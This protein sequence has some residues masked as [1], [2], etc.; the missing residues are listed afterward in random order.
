[1]YYKLWNKFIK[2]IVYL[3][4]NIN[5]N[6]L[7][8]FLGNY[9]MFEQINDINEHVDLLIYFSNINN[10]GIIID[11]H[12]IKKDGNK[13]YITIDNNDP[14]EILFIKRILIDLKNK[15]FE[16]KGGI[17][18]HSSSIVC[19]DKSVLFIGNKGAGKTT[20]M[21]YTL[22][23]DDIKY[24]SNERTG[25]ILENN[26]LLTYGNPT[27]IN[28]R[29]DSLKQNHILKQRLWSC[30]DK[31]KYTLYNSMNLSKDCSERIVVSFN[32]LAKCLD[33][34]I[35]PFSNLGAICNLVYDS[36]IDFKMDKVNF[37]TL[38]DI[39]DKSIIDG[40]FIQREKLNDMFPNNN[41][42]LQ[43]LLKKSKINFY[44][45]YQN[46]TKN[47]SKQIVKILKRDFKNEGN[48]R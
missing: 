5:V 43:D 31:D 48:F 20:N 8:M 4:K 16:L 9:L 11:N 12:S 17:F 28:V 47:N 10:D 2:L 45:I 34:E 30:I 38:N 22:L 23:Q 27:R 13:L 36:N 21:L 15:I 25:I 26:K 33:V 32:D 35:K 46:N 6:D 3:D 37:E 1:M 39:L 18:L 19:L 24:S 29:A 42:I 41:V 14:D 40:I 44:N 7:K